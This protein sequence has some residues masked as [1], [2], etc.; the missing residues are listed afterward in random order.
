MPRPEAI[1]DGRPSTVR[2]LSHRIWLEENGIDKIKLLNN[3]MIKK[4]GVKLGLSKKPKK[5]DNEFSDEYKLL[6]FELINCG[7]VTLSE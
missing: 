6:K 2:R 7:I 1:P 3:P 5:F 4:F